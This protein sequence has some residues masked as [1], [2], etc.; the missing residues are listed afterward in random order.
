MSCEFQSFPDNKSWD[1]C[2]HKRPPTSISHFIYI[3]YPYI[4]YLFHITYIIYIHFIYIN[5]IY[6]N[7]INIP[8]TICIL[9]I[10]PDYLLYII[11]IIYINKKCTIY[12]STI[13]Q[14]HLDHIHHHHQ[15]LLINFISISDINFKRNTDIIG[16][17]CHT[18][19][20]TQESCTGVDIQQQLHRSVYTGVNFT[21]VNFTGADFTHRSSS[22]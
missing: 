19:I 20:V 8:Y 10:S 5:F 7:F 12:A 22:R 17:S 6:V 2:F 18:G 14:L 16:T 3:R 4:S 9:Y 13:Y 11:C 15:N 1:S 21:E